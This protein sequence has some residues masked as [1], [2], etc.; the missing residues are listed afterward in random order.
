[1]AYITLADFKKYHSQLT[2]GVPAAYTADDDAVLQ[3]F[4]DQAQAEIESVTGRKFEGATATKYYTAADIDSGLLWLSDDLISITTLTNG[5]GAAIA[6]DAYS[7]LP[8]NHT[9]RYAVMLKSTT[10]WT[11]PV[12]GRVSILGSWG[13]SAT[14]PDDIKRLAYRLAYFYWLKRS[15]T[16]ETSV[17]NDSTAQVASEYPADIKSALRRYKRRGVA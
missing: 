3:M 12:D 13:Y 2:G 7:L 11:F 1:M 4:I 16:G 5:D 14:A 15:A 10:A 6:S 17:L 9:P 8:Y